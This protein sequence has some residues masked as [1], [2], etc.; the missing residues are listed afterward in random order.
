[1]VDAG[2]AAG[3]ELGVLEAVVD[4]DDESD[5]EDESDFGVAAVEADDRESLW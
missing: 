5:D 2:F 3:V 4:E 1:M